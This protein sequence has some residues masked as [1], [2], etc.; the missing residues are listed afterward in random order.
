MF[1]IYIASVIYKIHAESKR[2][3]MK[4]FFLFSAY[5]LFSMDSFEQQAEQEKDFDVATISEAMG[6]LIGK[7]LEHLGL[8]FDLNLLLKGIKDEKKGKPSPLTNE[9]CIQALTKIQEQIFYEDSIKNLR[10]AEDFL[11]KNALSENVFVLEKGK[12]QYRIEKNGNGAEVQAY[13]SPLIRYTG[14]Y[15]N[16]EVFGERRDE[17]LIS[18]DETIP[19]FSKGIIGMK[20]GEIRTIFIHPDL[21]YGTFGTLSP[22]SLLTFE[23][24]LLKADGICQTADP[25]LLKMAPKGE[26]DLLLENK[27]VAR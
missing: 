26:V 1:G 5:A 15:L 2:A 27:K 24:E 11:K 20:E 8:K 7:N 12:L 21:A 22:N 25:E 23:I 6:H 4:L 16:G 13:H 14:T 19:G 18:L 3:L 9:E 17:E 10:L